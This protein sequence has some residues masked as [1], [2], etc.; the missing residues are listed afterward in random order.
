MESITAPLLT[1]R[2]VAAHLQVTERTIQR[3][4]KIGQLPAERLGVKCVRI[5]RTDVEKLTQTIPAPEM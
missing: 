4:I 1:I 5:K 2:Q 3:W